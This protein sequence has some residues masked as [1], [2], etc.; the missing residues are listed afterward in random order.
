VE[1]KP[2]TASYVLTTLVFTDNCG[3]MCLSKGILQTYS[4]LA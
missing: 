1:S 3:R 4:N 2:K